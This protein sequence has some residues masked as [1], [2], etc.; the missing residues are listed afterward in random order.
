MPSPRII[1]FVALAILTGSCLSGCAT[2]SDK[3]K[4]AQKAVATGQTKRAVELLNERLDTDSENRLPKKLEDTDTLVL[5]ERATVLQAM[6]KYKLAARDMMVADD[7]MEY[8]DLTT[9]NKA[10]VGKWLYSGSSVTYR[11]PPYERLLLNTL[12]MINFLALRDVSG[13]KVEARRFALLEH[14]FVDKQDR[15]V[16]GGIL[17][18]GNYF[19]G[20][21]FEAAGDYRNAA[22]YYS[23]AYYFGVR[24]AGFKDRLVDLFAMTG[25]SPSE[26]TADDA[27][28]LSEIR[29]A[30]ETRQPPS[31]DAYGQKYLKGDTLIVV[32]TGLVPYKEPKRIPIARAMTYSQRHAYY[33]MTIAA[34][35][36]SNAQMLVA[37]GTL[38]SVNFP[39]LTRKG[40]PVKRGVNLQIAG[41]S[42]SNY[43]RVDVAQQVEAGW[44]RIAGSLMAA[45]ITRLVTRVVAGEATRQ[46]VQAAAGNAK[47]AGVAGALAGI[48]V[49]GAMSAADKPDTRSWMLLPAEVR[50]ARTQMSPGVHSITLKVEGRTDTRQLTVRENSLNL[51]NFSRLR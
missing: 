19:G 29:Q 31:F 33:G 22:R 20:A 1:T 2:Y 15:E 51:V 24:H 46:G 6:G 7:R 40:I 21:A 36:R 44:T 5:L 4:S 32:Q 28:A 30:A 45:A 17:G 27:D 12:N 35:T 34:S 10:K 39:M 48:A 8:L 41:S 26:L 25:F 49:Q 43:A 47:G 38:D 3:V 23:R 50:I 18:L 37:K 42:V 9:A 11:A 14:F 16:L 13:A